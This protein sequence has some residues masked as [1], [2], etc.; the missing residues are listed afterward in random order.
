AQ[1]QG[2][3]EELGAEIVTQ[4]K[5]L[6]EDTYAVDTPGPTFVGWNS[7]YTRQPIPEDQMREWLHT[8]L[9][10]IRGLK[11]RKV[12]EI[13]CGVGLLLEHLAPECEVYRGTDFSAEALKRLRSWVNT[14][15]EL[16]HVQ[17]E[18]S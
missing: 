13:G 6:Y 8:T 4:W 15:A 9:Q 1:H 3:P 18:Q 17:L 7:S 2:S 12:L 10:R 11:P 14:R 16:H 5:T